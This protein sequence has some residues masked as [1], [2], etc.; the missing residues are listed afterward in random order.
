MFLV[1][2]AKKAFGISVPWF[3]IADFTVKA[4]KYINQGETPK[5]AVKLAL[6]DLFLMN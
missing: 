6:M 4:L 2:L 1:K 3:L 5:K